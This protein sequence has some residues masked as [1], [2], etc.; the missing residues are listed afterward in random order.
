[1]GRRRSHTIYNAL[2]RIGDPGT[3]HEGCHFLQIDPAVPVRVVF[4]VGAWRQARGARG[5]KRLQG[6]VRVGARTMYALSMVVK[7]RAVT[8]AFC[9]KRKM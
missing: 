6:R 2:G 5:K 9:S 4:L 1:M 8:F 3:P 7:A